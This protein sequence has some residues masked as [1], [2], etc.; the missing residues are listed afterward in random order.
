MGIGADE[1]WGVQ[2]MLVKLQ[3]PPPRDAEFLARALAGPRPT[4]MRPRGPRTHHAC[5][6]RLKLTRYHMHGPALPE[7]AGRSSGCERVAI[8][9]EGLRR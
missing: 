9:D 1:G 4:P 2:C 5:A 7:R 3:R 8:R 6:L